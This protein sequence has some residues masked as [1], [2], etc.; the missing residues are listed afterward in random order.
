MNEA[1]ADVAGSEEINDD[2]FKDPRE[3]EVGVGCDASTLEDVAAGF[4]A[5]TDVCTEE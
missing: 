2:S 4:D 5:S 1:D 3:L